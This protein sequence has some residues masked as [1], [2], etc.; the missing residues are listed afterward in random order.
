ML[1]TGQEDTQQLRL[2]MSH[3]FESDLDFTTLL[4]RSG[5]GQYR[6]RL[7]QPVAARW[8]WTLESMVPD[9]W[10]LDGSVVSADFGDAAD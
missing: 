7:Q 10:R 9:G 8:H 1:L 4:I 3:P 5:P 6:G 2:Q